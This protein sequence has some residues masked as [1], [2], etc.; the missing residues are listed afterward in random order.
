MPRIVYNLPSYARG[1]GGGLGDWED[2]CSGTGGDVE[3]LLSKLSPT[4]KTSTEGAVTTDSTIFLCGA[5]EV[6][7]FVYYY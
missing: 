6:S 4:L 2:E 5:R 7:I 3:R 1:E